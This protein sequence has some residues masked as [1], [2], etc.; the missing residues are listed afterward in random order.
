MQNEM[1]SAL[2][3]FFWGKG[4]YKMEDHRDRRAWES[5]S[6]GENLGRHARYA[7][8][9]HA[10]ALAGC[11]E[12]CG[13]SHIFLKRKHFPCRGWRAWR[14]LRYSRLRWAGLMCHYGS[15]EAC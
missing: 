1:E 10:V 3:Q 14:C 8:T 11:S 6:D 4:D 9:S 2:L 15:R 5:G 7:E 13:W 12:V